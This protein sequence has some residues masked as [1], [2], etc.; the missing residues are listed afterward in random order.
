MWKVRIR[1]LIVGGLKNGD[2]KACCERYVKWLE[3]Y[4]KVEIRYLKAE[5]RN[6]PVE[7]ILCKEA[8]RLIK[9]L[10]DDDFIISLDRKGRMMD[11][12]S[13][14]ELLSKIMNEGKNLVFIVGGV[15]GLGGEILK[16]S[17]FVLSLSKM[18]FTH[19]IATFLILE[20][21]YRA[22]KIIRGERY[23]Y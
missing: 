11:S 12:E 5:N 20:Q 22:F 2:I 14:S 19:E 10:R 23:H 3:R 8:E 16:R 13:F 4:V 15:H 6:L 7:R 21:I 1:V 9:Y 17:N 18:T